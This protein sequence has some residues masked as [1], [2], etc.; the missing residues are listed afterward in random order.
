MTNI[1]RRGLIALA[2]LAAV[3]V[4]CVTKRELYGGEGYGIGAI[5][6]GSTELEEIRVS[7]VGD[8]RDT[9]H[10]Q[11]GQRPFKGARPSF[12]NP[13][14]APDNNQRIPNAV[15]VSWRDMP[16][17]GQPSEPRPRFATHPR[18]RL[19]RW[20]LDRPSAVRNRYLPRQPTQATLRQQ[21]F[22]EA[23]H[24]QDRGRSEGGN[25]QRP[26]P[27]PSDDRGRL[28]AEKSHDG[29]DER[30]PYDRRDHPP[31]CDR[32]RRA[33]EW[34]ASPPAWARGRNSSTSTGSRCQRCVRHRW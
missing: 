31:R 9:Y 34:R 3:G 25:Q 15:S 33:R 10:A 13:D 29:T 21:R 22:Q 23:K 32:V 27:I 1:A 26:T 17:Q 11:A 24:R 28:Q 19:R 6:F 20:Q 7:G 2:G 14:T 30:W 8:D 5:N 18:Y 16:A 4:G 12:P